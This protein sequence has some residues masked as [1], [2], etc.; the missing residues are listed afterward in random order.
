VLE[1]QPLHL[2]VDLT[3]PVRAREER[4]ADLDLAALRLVP[5][6]AGAADHAAVAPVE[7]DERAA[8]REVLLE[9]DTED[10]L[11]PALVGMELPD[12][13]IGRGLVE[14]VVI[15]GAQRPQLDEATDEMRLE[16]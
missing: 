3:A 7:D 9:E 12:E 15:V 10:V 8:G 13:R 4:P 11:P 14:G 16:I 6:V 2:P 1:H 5:V